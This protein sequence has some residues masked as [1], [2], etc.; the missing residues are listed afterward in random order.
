M[1]RQKEQRNEQL[2]SLHLEPLMT[3]R[4]SGFISLRTLLSPV[5][6]LQTS[7]HCVPTFF[8]RR[9]PHPS[10]SSC[11][12]TAPHPVRRT[13]TPYYTV[14]SDTES[15]LR[16]PQ[17]FSLSSVQLFLLVGN[18]FRNKVW[19]P[20]LAPAELSRLLGLQRPE[21]ETFTKKW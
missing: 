3:T 16:C 5:R 18:V 19:E 9:P 2:D 12:S 4:H 8:S 13:R 1:S 21:Q 15:A 7:G 14:L 11:M 17:L 20:L 6:K 10:E